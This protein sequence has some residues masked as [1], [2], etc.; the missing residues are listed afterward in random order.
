MDVEYRLRMDEWLGRNPLRRWRLAQAS[1]PSLG[2]ITKTLEMSR[3]TSSFWEMG[4][5]EPA[6]E[7]MAKLVALLGDP[8]LPQKWAG[9][10]AERPK[11]TG[12]S[13]DSPTGGTAER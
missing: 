1:Q 4:S 9:W 2:Q 3:G 6:P 5:A 8:Q 13:N 11:L 10:L 7:N 12:T